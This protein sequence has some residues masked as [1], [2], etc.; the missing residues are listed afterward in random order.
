MAETVPY[1]PGM[2]LGR[3]YDLQKLQP[4]L[5]IFPDEAL[6]TA[7]TIER[8][9]TSIRY[10]VVKKSRDINNILDVGG[11]IS[12]KVKAGLFRVEGMGSYL[13]EDRSKENTLEILA[14]AHVET[15][16]L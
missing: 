7:K 15:V 1:Q 12:L 14:K 4:G 13:K 9:Q 16:S 11:E 2:T 8:H 6:S 5:D 10:S 3:T